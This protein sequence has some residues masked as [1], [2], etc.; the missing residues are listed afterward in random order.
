MVTNKS[1]YVIYFIFLFFSGCYA[2]AGLGSSQTTIVA[3][4]LKNS[5]KTFSWPVPYNFT[6]GSIPFS[7]SGTFTQN[8]S[9]FF[10]DNTNFRLGIAMN[11]PT[12][13]LDVGPSATSGLVANFG[14]GGTGVTNYLSLNQNRTFFGFDGSN[15]VL[16]GGASRGLRLNVNNNTFGLGSALAITTAGDT[17][18]GNTSPGARLHVTGSTAATGVL[19]LTGAASQS[20]DYLSIQDSSSNVLARMTSTGAMT[21]GQSTDSGARLTLVGGTGGSALITLSRP[22]TGSAFSWSLAGSGLAFN[23]DTSGAVTTN[24]FGDGSQNQLF[25]GQRAKGTSEARTH[26]LSAQTYSSSVGS[27]V[28]GS[29]FFIAAAGGTGNAATPNMQFQTADATTSGSTAQSRTTKM[30]LSGLGNLSITPNTAIETSGSTSALSIAKTYNQSSGNAA[31]TDLLINRTETAVGSGNQLLIDAQ[32]AGSSKFAVTNTGAISL[33]GSVGTA[34][35]YLQSNGSSAPSWAAATPGFN[36]NAVTT[37][38]AASISDYVHCTSGTFTVTLPTAVGNAAKSIYILNTGSGIVTVATTSSQTVGG[39]SS[40]SKGLQLASVGDI[41]QVTSDGANWQITNYGIEVSASYWL[42]ANQT[43]SAQINFDSKE[44]DTQT[45]VVTG[46]GSWKFTAPIYG[47]YSIAGYHITSGSHVKIWKN[48]VSYKIVAS[49]NSGT[50]TRATP[51]NGIRLSAG[52]YI[53]FRPNTSTTITG[54]TL[55]SPDTANIF[56]QRVGN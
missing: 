11:V 50:P 33:S 17:G 24:I 51:A 13:Y 53:D 42:S 23:D 5:S 41:L 32:V 56:I 40:A 29:N 19:R 39:L 8:N 3:D 16:Q 47:T 28:A 22:G 21:I 1:K 20:G 30:T 38:Y 46:V 49:S 35:Q 36:Y 2:F 55:D 44:W 12:T 6:T 52:D 4:N 48:G 7:V 54:G 15:A 9:R 27:N 26:L 43:T 10:W 34:G 31:N 45:N 18:I 14:N 25:I 37:T